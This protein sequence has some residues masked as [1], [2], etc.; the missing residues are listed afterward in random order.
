MKRNFAAHRMDG[1]EEIQRL[2]MGAFHEKACSLYGIDCPNAADMLD[3]S[4]SSKM[5]S[6]S[7][8]DI[9]EMLSEMTQDDKECGGYSDPRLP[10]SGDAIAGHEVSAS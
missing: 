6:E 5:I 8:R 4:E 10:I 2:I 9:K 1:L 7:C 3:Y